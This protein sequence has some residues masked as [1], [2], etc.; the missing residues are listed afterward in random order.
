LAAATAGNLDGPLVIYCH[1]RCW[2]SWN[3]AKRAI[4]YGYRRIYWFPEGIE[5][6]TASGRPTATVEPLQ[7]PREPKLPGLAV[8]DI[9]LMGDL[10]G[11]ELVA[12]HAA[13][14][15][16]ESDRLRQKLERTGMYRIVDAAPAKATIDRL[17]SEQAYLHE[18]N[19]CDLEVG[20]ELHAELVLV[21]WVYRVSGLI[22]TLTY[23]IHD[24]DSGQIAARKSFDF[25]GDNDP[26]WNHAIDFMVR[27]LL[28][29]RGVPADRPG[30]QQESSTQQESVTQ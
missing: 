21:A 15:A 22:L 9:E 26:A 8:L 23:E 29:S 17:R 2:L 10:G 13:R 24:T 25:R 3:A 11:P 12:E 20:R 18:C 1:D 7:A 4:G 14:L 19:G 30:A 28:S 16:R 5:G 6:W 27:D